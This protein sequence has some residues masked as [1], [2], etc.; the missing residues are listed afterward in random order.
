MKLVSEPELN[1]VFR[2]FFF[3]YPEIRELKEILK[4]YKNLKK[5]EAAGERK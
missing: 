3:L 4:I 5:T 2:E 1:R